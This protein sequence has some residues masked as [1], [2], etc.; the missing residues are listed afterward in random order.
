MTT[1][2]S[3]STNVSSSVDRNLSH[4]V[5][6]ESD[7]TGENV[8]STTVPNLFEQTD[9]QRQRLEN[10]R[11]RLR[12]HQQ[13][14]S[15]HRR[16]I[17][18]IDNNDST[19]QP[20]QNTSVASDVDYSAFDTTTPNTAYEFDE[21]NTSSH[22][23][24]SAA[25]TST[26][27]STAVSN[28]QPAT[29]GTAR[30]KTPRTTA[31]RPRQLRVTRD[32]NR[33]L[34]PRSRTRRVN[35][36]LDSNTT[37][38]NP[39]GP[40]DMALIDNLFESG[41][42]SSYTPPNIEKVTNYATRTQSRITRAKRVISDHLG[43]HYLTHQNIS[44]LQRDVKPLA[45]L[46]RNV[47]QTLRDVSLGGSSAN[48]QLESTLCDMLLGVLEQ[49]HVV[50]KDCIAHSQRT[51]RF[52]EAM[53][54]HLHNLTDSVDNIQASFLHRQC[55]MANAAGHVAVVH[56]MIARRQAAETE[57]ASGIVRPTGLWG[58]AAQLNQLPM[59]VASRAICATH[60]PNS[61][62]GIA[63]EFT[64]RRRNTARTSRRAAAT[65]KKDD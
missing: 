7:L 24:S 50:V 6:N 41:M 39:N 52:L 57:Q 43:S 64:P 32:R 59:F 27:T 48:T 2:T 15:A 16:N 63:V 20:K 60:A 25:T 35:Q 28:P 49:W 51:H 55:H 9:E 37:S 22:F 8:S 34:H 31:P 47:S 18:E 46:V 19:N 53:Y 30:K 3:A 40:P 26:S 61:F 45:L 58:N 14:S 38:D 5:T 62:K 10:I 65:R 4:T 54:Q 1:N 36:S 56:G 12:E 42:Q 11:K 44:S 13:H 23:D 17:V 33:A 21:T 29:S